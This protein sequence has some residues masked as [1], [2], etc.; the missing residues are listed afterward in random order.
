MQTATNV[1]LW[2][3]RVWNARAS[4]VDRDADDVESTEYDEDVIHSLQLR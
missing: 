2:V 1:Y 4:E 3:A